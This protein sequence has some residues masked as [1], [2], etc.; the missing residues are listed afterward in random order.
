MHISRNTYHA[1]NAIAQIM[2]SKT[3]ELTTMHTM[4]VVENSPKT[5]LWRQMSCLREK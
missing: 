1:I 2:M 4:L 5:E 3:T